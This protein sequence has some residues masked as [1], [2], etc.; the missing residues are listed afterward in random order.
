MDRQISIAEA[1]N[2]L[3]SI[4]R[5]VEQGPSVK[6]TRHGKPVAVLLSTH[7]YDF[8]SRA[9]GKFWAELMAF[10]KTMENKNIEFTESD[11]EDLRDKS[12]GREVSLK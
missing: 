10:R 5:D 6:L 8:L 4:I 3:T 1:R 11:F 7:E 9:K 12:K 2:K